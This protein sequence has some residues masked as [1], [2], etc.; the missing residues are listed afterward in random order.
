MIAEQ[1][2]APV[3][4]SEEDIVPASLPPAYLAEAP[5]EEIK[6]HREARREYVA[7]LKQ[8]EPALQSI[9]EHLLHAHG[10]VH[11]RLWLVQRR[12][13]TPQD[14]IGGA[15]LTDE[16]WIRERRLGEMTAGETWQWSEYIRGERN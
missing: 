16:K 15:E 10:A 7:S 3:V 13:P 14:V 12:V 1:V 11:V 5:P 2:V 4:L 8:Q 9:A 6:R